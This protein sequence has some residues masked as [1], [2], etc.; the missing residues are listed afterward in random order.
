[1]RLLDQVKFTKLFFQLVQDPGRTELIF[2]A[3]EIVSKDRNEP[4]VQTLI[5]EIFEKPGLQDRFQEKYVGDLPPLEELSKFPEGSFGHIY[6][7]HMHENNLAA[8]LFPRFDPQDRL[9]YVNLRM[10]QDHDLWHALLGYGIS[11]EDELA[12]QAFSAAQLK[13]PF[14]VML[15][16]GGLLHLLKSEPLRA[17]TAIKEIAHG[18]E[19][20]QKSQFLL[21]FRLHDHLSKPIEDVR[22]ICGIAS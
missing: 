1:M 21:G 16:A 7:K 17:V 11:V 2:K 3:I 19:R 14:S 6:Y 18:F 22:E 4:I 20:G 8:D 13:T 5:E 10:Y 15:I 9:D 12:V